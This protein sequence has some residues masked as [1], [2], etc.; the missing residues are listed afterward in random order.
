LG[1]REQAVNI[2]VKKQA[3][4]TAPQNADRF[5]ILM[6]PNHLVRTKLFLIND[7][8]HKGTRSGEAGKVTAVIIADLRGG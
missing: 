2:T 8:L 6:S 1:S 7:W 5:A 4:R 3:A